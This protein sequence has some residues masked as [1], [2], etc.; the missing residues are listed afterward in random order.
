MPLGARSG[1]AP[2]G[3]PHTVPTPPSRPKVV[4][5]GVQPGGGALSGVSGVANRGHLRSEPRPCH[6]SYVR[7]ATGYAPAGVPRP[8]GT[9]TPCRFA[10]DAWDEQPLTINRNRHLTPQRGGRSGG[11][12]PTCAFCRASRSQ[13]DRLSI[14]CALRRGCSQEAP[15]VGGLV[16]GWR[17]HTSG[18]LSGWDQKA[19]GLRL[20]LKV[21]NLQALHAALPAAAPGT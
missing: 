10:C 7:G 11:A 19:A 3:L 14:Q 8:L 17:L 18:R 4:V 13:L 12:Q 21:Y 20:R 15:W 5:A 16:A 2:F 9:C 1:E 6:P